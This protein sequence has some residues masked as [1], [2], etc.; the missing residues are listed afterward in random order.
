MTEGLEEV[1]KIPT[2]HDVLFTAAEASRSINALDLHGQRYEEA[3]AEIDS[4]L[5]EMFMKGA[6]T[7]KIIHGKGN[8]VLQKLVIQILGKHQLVE[9]WRPSSRIGEE[10]AVA[11]AVLVERE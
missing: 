6:R 4:F 2:E 7:V 3:K 11:Y 1:G 9:A 8:G 5:H 10:N